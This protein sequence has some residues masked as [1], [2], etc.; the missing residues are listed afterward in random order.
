MHSH[1]DHYIHELT[2]KKILQVLEKGAWK[3]ENQTITSAF[4]NDNDLIEPDAKWMAMGENTA[5]TNAFSDIKFD[6]DVKRILDVGGG[7]YDSNRNYMKRARNIDLL[8]WDPYNRSHTHNTR[9]QTEVIDH[10]VD[11]ATSMSV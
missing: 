11:A 5:G 6:N 3:A 2:V 4:T 8:V 10:K 9:V 1:R 7:R